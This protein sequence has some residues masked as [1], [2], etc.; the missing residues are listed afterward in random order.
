MMKIN[1]LR[2]FTDMALG[3]N[4]LQTDPRSAGKA[5]LMRV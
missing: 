5:D 4:S 1:R 2:A 3:Q